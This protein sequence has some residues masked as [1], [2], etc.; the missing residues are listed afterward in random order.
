MS[1]VEKKTD[2]SESHGTV[3]VQGPVSW[4]GLA[5]GIGGSPMCSLWLSIV[6][7]SAAFSR[8]VNG[9]MT[10]YFMDALI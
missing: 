5:S 4:A 10:C 3:S 6:T 1:Y 8:G 2:D 9:A 7:G